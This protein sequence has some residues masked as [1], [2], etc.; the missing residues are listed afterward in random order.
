VPD[1]PAQ[2]DR[3]RFLRHLAAAGASTV[4][5]LAGSPAKA[6][7]E[8]GEVITAVTLVHGIPGRERELLEHLLSLA[9]ETRAEAGCLTYD[10]YRSTQAP[11]EFLRIERWKSPAD[12]EAHKGTAPL[13][14]SFERRKREGWTT[15]I[16][17]WKRVREDLV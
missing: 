9:P 13:R 1:Q 4:V 17:V 7:F 10:L 15:Q 8:G 3:R 16:T 6:E 5:G 14:A 2:P 12:L 11:G